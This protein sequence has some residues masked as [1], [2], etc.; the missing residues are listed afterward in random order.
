VISPAHDDE[1]DDVSGQVAHMLS[2]PQANTSQEYLFD[3][4]MSEHEP[5]DVNELDDAYELANVD[6]GIEREYPFDQLL[7]DLPDEHHNH[8]YLFDLDEDDTQPDEADPNDALYNEDFGLPAGEDQ[9]LEAALPRFQLGLEE[10]FDE[11]LDPLLEDGPDD[12][13]GPEAL[14]AAFQEHELI[15]NAYI[16]AFVQKVVYGATHRALKHQLKAAR[17][18]IAANPTV[19]PEEIAKMAQTIG[20]A[21]SRLG[22][23]TDAIITIFTLCPIC[24]RRYSSEYIATADSDACLNRNCEGILFTL[25]KLASGSKRRVSNMTYPFASPISWVQHMLSLPGMSELMQSWRNDD[26]DRG[27]SAPITNEEWIRN[28]DINKPI[29]DISEGWGWRSTL[30]GLERREHPNTGDII[31]ESALDPPIRFVSLPFGLSFTLN[32]DW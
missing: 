18:T 19:D 10:E 3:I 6:M 25:R 24:K 27:L 21:E 11:Q 28:V 17:R 2:P 30:A 8:H 5:D 14:C 4:Q 16:D 22:V 23:N 9:P 7:D 32:T 29:G 12:E 20:T 26:S 15:R 1:L 31:D 13:G